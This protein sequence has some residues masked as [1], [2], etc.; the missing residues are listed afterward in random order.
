MI[1][2]YYSPDIAATI[3]KKKKKE[4]KTLLKNRLCSPHNSEIAMSSHYTKYHLCS[5]G[6]KELLEI[7]IRNYLLQYI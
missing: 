3:M 2:N 6:E 4:R 1:I 5:F 7:N